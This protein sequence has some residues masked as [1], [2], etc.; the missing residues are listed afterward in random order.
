MRSSMLRVCLLKFERPDLSW[1]SAT[2]R[3]RWW[4]YLPGN[5]LT[6]PALTHQFPLQTRIPNGPWPRD[7]HCGGPGAGRS[8]Y[9]PHELKP[10]PTSACSRSQD[11]LQPFYALPWESLYCKW[12]IVFAFIVLY[13]RE[14][15]WGHNCK[16][17][18]LYSTTRQMRFTK[19]LFLSFF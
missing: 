7:R 4:V 1:N 11:T 16:N 15:V 14:S 9:Y 19:Y 13:P 12:L 17:K 2:Q 8:V 3:H 6:L 10:R 5:W 18:W